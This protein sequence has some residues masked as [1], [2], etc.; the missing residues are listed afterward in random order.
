MRGLSGHDLLRAWE[1][2]QRQHVVDR[3]LTLLG[4]GGSPVGGDDVAALPVGRRDGLLLDLHAATFGPG[5]RAFCECGGCA[6]RLELELDLATVRSACVPGDAPDAIDV[7]GYRVRVRPPTSHDLAAAV[8]AGERDTAY[9]VL[10]ERCLS[11]CTEG[12]VPVPASALPAEVAAA[13]ADHVLAVDRG[14][15]LT[16]EVTCPGCGRAASLVLDVPRFVWAELA[17]E[18]RRLLHEVFSLARS[19]GWAEEDILSMS[20]QRRRAYLELGS[21]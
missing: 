18:A 13:A 5:L 8:R 2:G 1:R 9:R 6:E 11:A 7:G 21:I 14:A 19:T 20:P 4:L 16:V 15:E 10:L 3:A 12:G 17:A